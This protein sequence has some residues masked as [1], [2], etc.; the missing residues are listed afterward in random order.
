MCVCVAHKP[1]VL[2]EIIHN[3]DYCDV[4][5]LGE[6]LR[7]EQE[8]LQLHRSSLLGKHL[9]AT[10]SSSGMSIYGR[11][12]W[13]TQPPT[14]PLACPSMVGYHRNNPFPA[15]PKYVLRLFFVANKTLVFYT[16]HSPTYLQA[17][18]VTIAIDTLFIGIFFHSGNH[19]DHLPPGV[20]S[21]SNYEQVIRQVRYH[22]WRPAQTSDRKFRLTCSELNGRYTSN[23]FTLEVR[24]HPHSARGNL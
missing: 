3:L 19:G 14:L 10:N 9:D 11:L 15:P 5:V 1:G 6:E 2:E 16:T 7:T 17:Q 8:S 20:D 12:Q 13:E 23:E 4:L 21:M 24:G 22:N 18:S